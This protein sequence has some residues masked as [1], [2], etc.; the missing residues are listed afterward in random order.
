M[1]AR[2]PFAMVRN[3]TIKNMAE[4]AAAKAARPDV[5]KPQ[6]VNGKW[7]KPKMSA[8]AIA[9]LRKQYIKAGKEW[10][11]DIP[12]KIVE[13]QVPFKGKLRDLRKQERQIEIQ[14]CMARM[15]KL[16]EEYRI[17]ERERRKQ[18]RLSKLTGLAK[19]LAE[20]RENPNIITR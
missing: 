18:L 7:R 15:P 1:H 11:W 20:P 9:R 10:K 6:F 17:K 4:V 12:K 19:L 2:P 3:I 8:L 5:M 13:K 16:I 14:R